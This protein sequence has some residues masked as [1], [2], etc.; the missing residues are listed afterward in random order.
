MTLSDN[1][2]SHR[3]SSGNPDSNSPAETTVFEDAL[4]PTLAYKTPEELNKIESNLLN[5][6]KSLSHDYITSR[7]SRISHMISSL[8]YYIKTFSENDKNWSKI[9]NFEIETIESIKTN[10]EDLILSDLKLSNAKDIIDTLDEYELELKE[11]FNN[12]QSPLEFD[13]I[14]DNKFFN[15]IIKSDENLSHANTL[16]FPNQF[17]KIIKTFGKHLHGIKNENKYQI[18]LIKANVKSNSKILWNQYYNDLISHKNNLIND[19]YDELNQLYKEYNDINENEKIISDNKFYNK[20]IISI[21]NLKSYENLNQDNYYNVDN[22]YYKKNKIELTNIKKNIE[23]KLKKFNGI[24]R[25]YGDQIKLNACSGLNEN[26]I[27]NDLLI[28]RSLGNTKSSKN[29]DQGNTN[30]ESEEVDI[31]VDVDDDEIVNDIDD[32]DLVNIDADEFDDDDDD[33]DELDE[34]EDDDDND[35]SSLLQLPQQTFLDNSFFETQQHNKGSK[36]Q[37]DTAELKERELMLNLQLKLERKMIADREKRLIKKR[38]EE[39]NTK[40]D[41]ELTSKELME[42]NYRKLLATNKSNSN[43]DLSI[44]DFN[45]IINSSSSSSNKRK[46]SLPELP[47]LNKFP[48]LST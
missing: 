14:F 31:A 36:E 24:Q 12:I 7:Q 17:H 40:Q 45:Q 13:E 4:L 37:G 46:L 22:R 35:L 38:K 42:R 23:S 19:T 47:P 8:V 9:Y 29:H 10:T 18:N 44:G 11:L 6:F 20:S 27:D 5:E 15:R 1:L 41:N 3:S 48:K 2:R 43:S 26:E 34:D 30:V 39:I 21:N 16:P 33:D 25:S 28:M 32:D